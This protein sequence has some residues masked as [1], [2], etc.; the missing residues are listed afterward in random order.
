MT[1]LA[2]T[3]ECVRLERVNNIYGGRDCDQWVEVIAEPTVPSGD[4]SVNQLLPPLTIGQA[5][6]IS[7]TCVM[8]LVLAVGF[9]L[10]GKLIWRH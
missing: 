6:E 7:N 3:Y 1:T 9:R 10:I 2:K 5:M 4:T 8:L